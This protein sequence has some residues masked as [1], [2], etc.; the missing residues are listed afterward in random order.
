[1]GGCPPRQACWREL[2]SKIDLLVVYTLGFVNPLG[3]FLSRCAYG[4]N[5]GIGDVSIYLTAQV[6]GDVPVMIAAEKEEL[7][8]RPLVF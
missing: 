2:F 7:L 4:A 1:M 6:A 5:P 8:P 3:D